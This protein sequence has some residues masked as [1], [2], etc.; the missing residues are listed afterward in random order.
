MVQNVNSNK[1]T[2]E[3]ITPFFRACESRN[4]HLVDYLKEDGV[5]I[6]KEDSNGITLLF[7]V[8]ENGNEYKKK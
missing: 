3:G 6:N 5:N 7:K 2:K 1:E 4:E 8:C